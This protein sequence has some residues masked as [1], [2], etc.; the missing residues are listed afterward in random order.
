MAR[1][2]ELDEAAATEMAAENFAEGRGITNA[3]LRDDYLATHL[4]EAE[5]TR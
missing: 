2:V 4:D 1:G 3:N 5:F